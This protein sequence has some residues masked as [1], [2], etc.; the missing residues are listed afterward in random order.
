MN[1]KE[2]AELQNQ[3]RIALRAWKRLQKRIAEAQAIIATQSRQYLVE[4]DFFNGP[5]IMGKQLSVRIV[6][7]EG[8]SQTESVFWGYRGFSKKWEDWPFLKLL[9]LPFHGGVEVLIKHHAV[10]L[11]PW[12]WFDRDLGNGGGIHAFPK[13]AAEEIWHLAKDYFQAVMHVTRNLGKKYGPG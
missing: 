8:K 7:Y 11:T 13:A 12:V 10:K 2:A 4:E 1:E 6:V 3:G 5:K 9:M